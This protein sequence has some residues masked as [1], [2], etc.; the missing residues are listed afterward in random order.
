[1]KYINVAVEGQTEDTF[2]RDVLNPYLNPKGIHL[3]SKLLTTS[4]VK[5]GANFKGGVTTYGKVRN[6]IMRLLN[7][8]NAVLITT[9]I[10]FFGIPTDFPQYEN[11]PNEGCYQKVKFLEQAFK[12]NINSD[13][14]SPY[15]MVHEFEAMLF[16]S[17]QKIA[18]AFPNTDKQTEIEIIT[19]NFD[20]PEE[21]NLDNPPSKRLMK[22]Y[23]DYDKVFHGFYI[24]DEIGVD[25][26]RK[27]CPHFNQWLT[28]LEAY[29]L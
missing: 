28:Q 19:N 27:Q 26:I 20:S 2:V 25:T 12:Q 15:L 17:P 29:A 5:S 1:M 10:D 6:D 23:K 3:S 11:M 7:D 16:T 21:I 8:K 9:M 13:K 18:N 22:L 4:I 24:S 14:F